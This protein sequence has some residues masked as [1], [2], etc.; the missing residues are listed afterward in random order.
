[1]AGK[2]RIRVVH[3]EDRKLSTALFTTEEKEK[4]KSTVKK[5]IHVRKG[6]PGR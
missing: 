3:L 2:P 1:M 4:L 5:R 6:K